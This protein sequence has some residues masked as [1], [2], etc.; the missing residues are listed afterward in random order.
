MAYKEILKIVP[1]LQA[2]AIT[3]KNIPRIDIKKS[4]KFS[5]KNNSKSMIKK[6]VM[7]LT[8]IGLIKPTSKLINNLS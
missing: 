5:P 6:S 4:K 2:T 3:M 1:G 7:T 8:G